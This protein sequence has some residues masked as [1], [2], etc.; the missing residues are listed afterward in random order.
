MNSHV[1]R[2]KTTWYATQDTPFGAIFHVL[3]PYLPGPDSLVQNHNIAEVRKCP[4]VCSNSKEP[5]TYQPLGAH[6]PLGGFRFLA[7]ETVVN[8]VAVHNHLQ[9]QLVPPE[10]STHPIAQHVLQ[11]PIGPIYCKTCK[12]REHSP[13]VSK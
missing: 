9:A 2:H 7:A 1:T 5:H 13:L 8:G 4:S 12:F 10:A 6:G 3:T 11:S